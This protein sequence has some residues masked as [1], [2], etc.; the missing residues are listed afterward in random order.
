MCHS[1]VSVW[2]LKCSPELL[3]A[4]SVRAEGPDGGLGPGWGMVRRCHI[5]KIAQQVNV[6]EGCLCTEGRRRS[7]DVETQ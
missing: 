7:P 3:E 4:C 2:A 6:S 1:H 5:Q